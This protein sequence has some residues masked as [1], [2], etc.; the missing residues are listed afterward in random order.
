[1]LHLAAPDAYSGFECRRTA[2][3]GV[4]QRVLV[5]PQRDGKGLGRR[6]KTFLEQLQHKLAGVLLYLVSGFLQ[7]RVRVRLQ[8]MMRLTLLHAVVHLDGFQ[9]ALWET[10]RAIPARRQFGLEAADHHGVQLSALD[11][12]PSG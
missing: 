10:R 6:K 4:G 1:L 11:L 12:D 8:E 2:R 7:P 5:L 9:L 3:A